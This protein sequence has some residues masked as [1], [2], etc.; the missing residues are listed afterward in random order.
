M[1]FMG[2]IVTEEDGTS[3]VDFSW[4]IE[5]LAGFLGRVRQ[6]YDFST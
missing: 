5:S 4:Q 2:E 1:V 3:K 6:W